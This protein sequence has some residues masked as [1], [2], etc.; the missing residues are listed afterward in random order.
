MD[1]PFAMM[2]LTTTTTTIKQYEH[3]HFDPLYNI[4]TTSPNNCSTADVVDAPNDSTHC[5]GI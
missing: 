1:V 4:S 3:N 2:K 5:V